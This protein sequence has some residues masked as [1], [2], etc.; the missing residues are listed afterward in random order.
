MQKQIKKIENIKLQSSELTNKQAK[1]KFIENSKSY[2]TNIKTR[3]QKKSKLKKNKN[4]KIKKILRIRRKLKLKRFKRPFQNYRLFTLKNYLNL[5]IVVKPN[6]IFFGSKSS[7][8]SKFTKILSASFFKTKITKKRIKK[9]LLPTISKF[10]FLLNKKNS[11]KPYQFVV[12]NLTIPT[13][14]KKRFLKLFKRSFFKKMFSKKRLIINIKAKKIFN[15]C[16]VKK[17]KK[18]KRKKFR[19]LK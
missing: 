6:N 11:V 1:D 12:I 17:Q 10:F 15:G 7:K 19:I 2:K 13:R 4:W 14:L 16:S 3:A 9:N 8:F 5:D 18:R